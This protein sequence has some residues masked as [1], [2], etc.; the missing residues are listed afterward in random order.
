MIINKSNI[1]ARGGSTSLLL[2]LLLCIG[3][4]GVNSAQAQCVTNITLDVGDNTLFNDFTN[5][6]VNGSSGNENAGPIGSDVI[7]GTPAV[8]ADSDGTDDIDFSFEI[9]NAFD[10]YGGVIID[11]NAGVTHDVRQESTGIRGT[12]PLGASGSNESSTGDVRGYCVTV[13]FDSDILIEAQDLDV[14]FSS[15]NTAGEAYESAAIQFLNTSGMPFSGSTIS[16]SDYTGF[17][18]S[19][20]SGTAVQPPISS[21]PWGSL[22][23]GS[24]GVFLA[25]DTNTIV[26]SGN[27]LCS[28]F[29]PATLTAPECGTDGPNDSPTVNAATDAGVTATDMVGGFKYCVL[30]EDVALTTNDGDNTT[31]STTFTST[32]TELNIAELCRASIAPPAGCVSSTGVCEGEDVT[33]QKNWW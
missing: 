27:G 14:N 15:I 19:Q 25:D 6:I 28:P 5:D 33:G 8:A 2:T 7:D 13:M 30:L 29:D 1:R 9:I 21:A 22:T 12:T 20:P 10:V 11:A 23:S 31:T 26:F 17:Y 32:M 4:L 18:T 16:S 3:V 24:G